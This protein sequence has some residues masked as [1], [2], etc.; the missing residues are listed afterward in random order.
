MPNL[1]SVTTTEAVRRAGVRHGEV[2]APAEEADPASQEPQAPQGKRL[3]VPR[4]GQAQAE[5]Q[6]V[7]STWKEVAIKPLAHAAGGFLM[8]G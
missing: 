5:A 8:R 7:L 1:L 6:R 2:R 3:E 4:D